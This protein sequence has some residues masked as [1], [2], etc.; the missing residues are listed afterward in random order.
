MKFAARFAEDLA[1]GQ[2][3]DRF[4]E[5]IRRTRTL[6]DEVASA[7]WHLTA[8]PSRQDLRHVQRRLSRLRRRVHE[9]EDALTALE[10]NGRRGARGE[11]PRRGQRAIR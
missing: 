4:F 11:P 10:E 7:F 5:A 3:I 9:L 2:R 6:G 8:M 1:G